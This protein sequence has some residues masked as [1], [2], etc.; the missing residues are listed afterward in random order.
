MPLQWHDMPLR[1]SASAAA[2]AAAASAA[3]GLCY[4]RHPI[5]GVIA[6]RYQSLL[7]FSNVDTSLQSRSIHMLHLDISDV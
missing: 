1:A 7:F 4:A 5:C 2:A 3:A 6:L